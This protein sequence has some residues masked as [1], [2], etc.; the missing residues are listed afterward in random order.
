MLLRSNG[1]FGS[2]AIGRIRTH[3]SHRNF[4]HSGVHVGKLV[5]INVLELLLRLG[6]KFRTVVHEV[7][8]CFAHHVGSDWRKLRLTV[9][10]VSPLGGQ[11][12]GGIIDLGIE[13]VLVILK[14]FSIRGDVGT[15][16]L[17]LVAHELKL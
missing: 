13:S 2:F 8:R 9:R 11:L 14:F 7:V 17:V 1:D 12:L 15:S 3:W 10:V 5:R 16:I 6:A 4:S